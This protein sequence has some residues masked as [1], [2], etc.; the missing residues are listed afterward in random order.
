MVTKRQLGTDKAEMPD[1]APRADK[2]REFHGLVTATMSDFMACQ[3][4]TEKSLE[5]CKLFIQLTMAGQGY[6]CPAEPR[7]Q[8]KRKPS[9]T[10][11]S[12]QPRARHFSFS[13]V[14]QWELSPRMKCRTYR[15]DSPALQLRAWP[16]RIVAGVKHHTPAC[17]YLCRAGALNQRKGVSGTFVPS[18]AFSINGTAA[19]C[20]TLFPFHLENMPLNFPGSESTTG[21]GAK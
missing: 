12:E 6:P 3:R 17:P 4:L 16:L 1:M 8:Y 9:P 18:N 14:S 11:G 2:S 21:R 20:V 13:Q 19:N 15:G 7:P 10:Q 5:L